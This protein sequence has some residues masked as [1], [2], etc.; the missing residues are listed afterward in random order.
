MKHL[1]QSLSDQTLTHGPV[2]PDSPWIS[3]ISFAE[4]INNCFYRSILIRCFNSIFLIFGFGSSFMFFIR[5]SI[6]D[7]IKSRRSRTRFDSF[8]TLIGRWK[9][10]TCCTIRKRIWSGFNIWAC[11]LAWLRG[12]RWS[13][14]RFWLKITNLMTSY[15]LKWKCVGGRSTYFY[16]ISLRIWYQKVAKVA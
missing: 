9:S 6:V 14:A 13:H 16:E 4:H 8:S 12:R 5:S 15:D 10:V 3:N 2:Q 1:D 11:C 7:T